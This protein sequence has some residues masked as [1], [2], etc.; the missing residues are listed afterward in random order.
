M[1]SA[2]TRLVL[3][4][5]L[6][7]LFAVGWF[8]DKPIDFAQPLS[9]ILPAFCLIA[10]IAVVVTFVIDMRRIRHRKEEECE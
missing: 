4:L 10:T 8:I 7:G 5:M 2:L 1:K 6:L 3:R 9:L